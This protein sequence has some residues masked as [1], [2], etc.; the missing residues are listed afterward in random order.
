M[1]VRILSYQNAQNFGALLQAY[2][3]MK[4]VQKLGYQDVCFLNYNPDYLKRRYRLLWQLFPSQKNIKSFILFLVNT[5]FIIFNRIRRNYVF[6]KSRS[7]LLVQDN[8]E[9][10]RLEDFKD[11]E[12]ETLIC[13]SDQIWSTWITGEPD[14]VFYGV[15]DYKNIKCRIAYAPSTELST[16]E[17]PLFVKK[18]NAL[19][20]NFDYLS[21]RE[22]SVKEHLQEMTGRD[23][24]LCVDP[25]ILCGPDAFLEI[26]SKRLVK[27]EYILVYAYN[28]KDSLINDIIKSIPKHEQYE[29]HYI[30]FGSSGL[31]ATL[32]RNYHAEISIEEFLSLFKYASYVVTNSF[33][34]LAFSLLFEKNFNVG[35]VEKKSGRCE[36]LLNEIGLSG[37]L[38]KQAGFVY[39]EYPDYPAVNEKIAEIRQESITYLNKALNYTK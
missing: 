37:R 32:N 18:M 13:G 21:A 35:Y 25:T 14:P 3:L 8:K 7:R 1:N 9:L 39:W 19:L 5:P 29:I 30:L 34:G 38:I 10:S 31:L 22:N 2:G 4:T 24:A 27:K 26:A 17:N 6:N 33:H 11:I 28:P 20:K 23:V 36:S 16:F 15:G 12:C